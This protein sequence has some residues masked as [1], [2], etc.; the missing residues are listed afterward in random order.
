MLNLVVLHNC[1]EHIVRT[2]I[3][4]VQK[5]SF[6]FNYS[7][8]KLDQYQACLEEADPN[9]KEC[10]GHRSKLQNLCETRWAA[11]SDAL[12][13]FKASFPVVIEALSY[14][15]EDDAECRAYGTSI[16]RFDFIMHWWCV[17]MSRATNP[18][19]AESWPWTGHSRGRD[20]CEDIAWWESRR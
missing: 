15:G 5:V 12:F 20:H 18:K 3:D 17:N 8:K 4:T 14:L 1:K 10:I 2:F 7:A 11:T 13:A 9:T 19:T 16:C 6:S